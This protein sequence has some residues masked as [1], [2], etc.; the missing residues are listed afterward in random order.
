MLLMLH[1]SKLKKLYKELHEPGVFE[2]TSIHT[3]DD[4]KNKSYASW[5]CKDGCDYQHFLAT[6]GSDG[7][8]YLCDHNTMPGGIALGNVINRPFKE[9]WES[10][11]R[12]YLS[13]GIEHTCQCDV[14]PP[15]GN[16]VNF[17]LKTCE[18]LHESMARTPLRK[19]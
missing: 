3:R 12:E 4:V 18:K 10:D 8:L 17:F 11:K 7:N 9:V 5:Q 16:R 15:F 2:V 13:N 1:L 19:P 6:V 14:C